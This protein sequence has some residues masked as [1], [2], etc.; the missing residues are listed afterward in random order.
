MYTAGRMHP[1][2]SLGPG[3]AL[4]LIV[5]VVAE[6]LGVGRTLPELLQA[7]RRLLPERDGAQAAAPALL[8]LLVLAVEVRL[9]LGQ[10]ALRSALPHAL[11]LLNALEVSAVGEVRAAVLSQ[12]E[13]QDH[14]EGGKE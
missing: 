4:G 1:R 11:V 12:V 7:P 9:Q 13:R 10:L 6:A 2:S 3:A 14:L 8:L 5:E